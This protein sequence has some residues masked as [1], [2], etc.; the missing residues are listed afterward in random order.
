MYMIKAYIEELKAFRH[1][2]A[3]SKDKAKRALLKPLA[4]MDKQI[5][6]ELFKKILYRSK[7][8]HSLAF[9]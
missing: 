9:F 3:K 5:P 1:E 7:V 4:L 2:V 8:L 6:K